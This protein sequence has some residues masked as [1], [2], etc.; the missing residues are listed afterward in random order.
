M[1][2]PLSAPF[3]SSALASGPGD[4]E[5]G[6]G[7]YLLFESSDCHFAPSDLIV[8]TG[9]FSTGTTIRLLLLDRNLAYNIPPFLVLDSL[10]GMVDSAS[11]C[12]LD[13]QSANPNKPS[14]IAPKMRFNTQIA[15][16]LN[17]S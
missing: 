6:Q 7:A 9:Y 10:S 12:D 5:S 15:R 4:L 1:T 13:P 3:G 16:T 8:M 17:P 14:P 11:F 2:S